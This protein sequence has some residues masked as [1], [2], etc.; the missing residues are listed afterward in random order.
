MCRG[1]KRGREGRKERAR[2][3]LRERGGL[4]KK[5]KVRRKRGAKESMVE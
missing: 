5:E 4:D 3:G 1:A 2:E